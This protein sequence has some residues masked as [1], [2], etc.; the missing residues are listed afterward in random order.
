MKCALSIEKYGNCISNIKNT[1]PF[2]AAMP[3]E[4]VLRC[5]FVVQVWHFYLG[6]CLLVTAV[7]YDSLVV[8][9]LNG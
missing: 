7:H 1:L 9:L 8:T 3:C 2:Q 4:A 6:V 5:A